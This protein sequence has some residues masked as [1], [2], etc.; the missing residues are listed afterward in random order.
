[1]VIVTCEAWH[2]LGTA[3]PAEPDAQ[4]GKALHE[5]QQGA[6]LRDIGLALSSKRNPFQECSQNRAT[7]YHEPLP[8]YAT[9]ITSAEL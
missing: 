2:G 8:Q 7:V 4:Q 1:M 6:D 9:G 3:G 5:C